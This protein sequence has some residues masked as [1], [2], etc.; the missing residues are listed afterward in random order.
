VPESGEILALVEQG[1]LRIKDIAPILGVTKQRVSQIV[2]EREDFP[3]PAK[4]IRT[5]SV[6]RLKDV[7]R[8]RDTKPRAWL[9]ERQ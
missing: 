4:V 8:W 5:A 2:A 6:W 7:E 9:P 1:Y 3:Q